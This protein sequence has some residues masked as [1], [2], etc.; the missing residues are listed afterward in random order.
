MTQ[1]VIAVFDTPDTAYQ[2]EEILMD[3]EGIDESCFH[4]TAQEGDQED[5]QEEI[6]SFLGELFGSENSEQIDYYAERISQGGALLSIDLPDDIAIGPVREAMLNAGATDL[7]ASDWQEG[8]EAA[9]EEQS[10]SVPIIEE[11][12][13]VGKQQVGKG[14]VRVTSRLEE[15]PVHEEVDLREEHAA[16][17]RRAVDRPIDPEDVDAMGERS[18]EIEETAERPVVGKSAR[19]AEEIEVGKESVEETR[20]VEDTVRHTEVDVE[21]EPAR[22]TQR[23]RGSGKQ[24]TRR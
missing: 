7:E 18:V 15:T 9:P 12:L 14:K 8:E 6:R 22:S 13:E 1:T 4:V 5:D 3:Q 11:E 23:K 10:Q 16:I 24:S 19:V 2:V 20:M 21:K 17:K